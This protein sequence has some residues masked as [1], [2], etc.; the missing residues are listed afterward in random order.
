[1][2][3]LRAD[4][5]IRW[6][7]GVCGLVTVA[8]TLLIVVFVFSESLPA[9]SKVGLGFVRDESWYPSPEA[10][11]GQFGMLPMLGATAFCTVGAVLISTPVGIGCALFSH[12]YAPA[13]LA[14]PF[15][16]VIEL[17]AGIP[18]VVYG[19]WGLVVLVPWI[20]RWQAPG[21][22]LLA[23]ILILGLMILPTL[24]LSCTAALSSLPLEDFQAAAAT[25]LSRW[26]TIRG[27]VLP[28]IAPSLATGVFLQSGRALGET[29]AV[30]M[31]CGNVVQWPGSLFDPVRPLTANIALE[32][33]YAMGD[34]RSALFVSGLAL[35]S[36]VFLLLWLADLFGPAEGTK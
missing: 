34:H 17:L 8:V 25:G 28:A 24:T 18:S 9:L 7:T 19:F 3:R 12:F 32:M 13:W 15:R 22:S 33:S 27:V 29:M 23:G 1:M 21:A 20:G 26:G 36:A 14:G 5:W 2:F 35:L 11:Q 30:L 16:R 31:V 10:A 4:L 6:L